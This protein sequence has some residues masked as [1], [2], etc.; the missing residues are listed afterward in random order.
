MQEDIYIL[1]IESSCDDT[2][3]AVLRNG[4]LL[5]NVTASQEVHK[6]YGGVVPEEVAPQEY[7]K[8]ELSID[9]HIMILTT[10]ITATM[11]AMMLIAAVQSTS[12]AVIFPY[13]SK[14]IVSTVQ[15][16]AITSIALLQ[17]NLIRYMTTGEQQYFANVQ[18]MLMMLSILSLTDSMFADYIY[19]MYM[20]VSLEP[21]K[22]PESAKNYTNPETE[23][24]KKDLQ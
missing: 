16:T 4:V 20:P 5:S 7:I 3:A 2:S 17:Y 10:E 21:E 24:G 13:E 9:E 8:A 23:R 6:A 14:V 15:V 1:G 12:F 22:I 19:S 18:D 11:S